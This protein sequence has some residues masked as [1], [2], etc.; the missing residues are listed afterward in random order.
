MVAPFCS[1]PFN[2]LSCASFS[3]LH[4]LPP[5]PSLRHHRQLFIPN[6]HETSLPVKD[7]LHHRWR[8][9]PVYMIETAVHMPRVFD[10]RGMWCSRHEVKRLP[11]CGFQEEICC[12]L[13]SCFRGVGTYS[14]ARRFHF[15]V[16]AF[17]GDDPDS[18]VWRSWW[19]GCPRWG[20]SD[21]KCESCVIHDALSC[22]LWIRW[23][24]CHGKRMT[25]R[26]ATY[27][28]EPR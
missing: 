3:Q 6:L 25:M 10:T 11:G 16:A 19:H 12:Y 20:C 24:G 15:V 28:Y 9:P 18:G 23:K 1:C 5:P 8:L 2:M 7:H 26:I 21:W 27:I 4:S 13:C 14:V 22:G 17:V